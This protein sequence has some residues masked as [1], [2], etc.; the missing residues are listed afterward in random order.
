MR[1]IAGLSAALMLAGMGGALAQEVTDWSG[2]YAS[3]HAGYA[4]D[5]ARA[6]STT[7]VLPAPPLGVL[8]GTITATGANTRIDGILGGLGAGYTFQHNQFVLGVDGTIS[9]GGLGKSHSVRT[10]AILRNGADFVSVE[11]LGRMDYA[12][13][14]YTAL[15]AKFGVAFDDGWMGYVRGGLAVAN[16]SVAG[17]A[18]SVLDG[19]SPVLVNAL[20][21]VPPLSEAASSSS[22]QLMMGPTFGLGV[23][24]M[25]MQNVSLGVS[26]DYVSLPDVV[27][28]GLYTPVIGNG[29]GPRTFA[30]GFHTLKAS[31]KYHF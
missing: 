9:A 14:W 8:A 30:G 29:I 18:T 22:E 20:V 27:T 10:D 23:D 16:V 1:A 24:K 13:D 7:D 25:V 31:V 3:V 26:Y 17:R 11:S 5:P 19:S 15:T 21:G 28:T 6:A 2:F 12:V 4:L